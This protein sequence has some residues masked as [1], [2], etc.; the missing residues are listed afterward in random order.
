[1]SV[2]SHCNIV[3]GSSPL[4]LKLDSRLLLAVAFSLASSA[5]AAAAATSA[6]CA[7][8]SFLS[9]A[10][11]ASAIGSKNIVLYEANLFSQRSSRSP[12]PWPAGPS[13][14]VRRKVDGGVDC[15]AGADLRGVLK[16][17]VL[18]RDVPGDDGAGEDA[19]RGEGDAADGRSRLNVGVP[20]RRGVLVD[21]FQP[22]ESPDGDIA[23]ARVSPPRIVECCSDVLR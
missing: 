21:G 9:C 3:F 1:M 20:R 22:T 16:L 17:L 2:L 14:L 18:P 13:T 6:S 7:A 4:S 19:R 11:L 5:A 23:D 10:L 12:S 8:I 15:S